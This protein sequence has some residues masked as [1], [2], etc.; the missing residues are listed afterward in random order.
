MYLN[1]SNTLR[2]DFQMP[3]RGDPRRNVT[4]Q[5]AVPHVI[6]VKLCPRSE[7]EQSVGNATLLRSCAC[8]RN[9]WFMVIPEA[10]LP[11]VLMDRARPAQILIMSWHGHVCTVRKIL[12]HITALAREH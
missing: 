3:R 11:S 8:R 10:C 4:I 9:F 5:G 1:S 6:T 2:I 12:I 7:S